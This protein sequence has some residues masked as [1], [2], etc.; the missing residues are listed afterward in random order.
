MERDWR[1]LPPSRSWYWIRMTT[2]PPSSRG[3]SLGLSPSSPSQ[4]Q[5][6]PGVH[7][8]QFVSLQGSDSTTRSILVCSPHLRQV[9]VLN[10]LN[11]TLML[12]YLPIHTPMP[13]H[14]DSNFQDYWITPSTSRVTV[15]IVLCVQVKVILHTHSEL[16]TGQKSNSLPTARKMTQKVTTGMA[17]NTSDSTSVYIRSH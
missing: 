6:S 13:Q 14:W 3:S 12:P 4:V 8:L 1:T 15:A 5:D 17:D 2:D 9:V 16:G 10:D 11:V 7:L